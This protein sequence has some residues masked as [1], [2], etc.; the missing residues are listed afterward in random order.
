VERGI[1]TMKVLKE[2]DRKQRNRIEFNN[3]EYYSKN[4][5]QTLKPMKSK[6]QKIIL[7]KYALEE[8]ETIEEVPEYELY[9]IL[10]YSYSTLILS[11]TAF[12]GSLMFDNSTYINKNGKPSRYTKSLQKSMIEW[13]KEMKLTPTE[14]YQEK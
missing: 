8:F 14:Y 5:E 13:L 4:Y 12:T 9:Q 3:M 2:L 7:Q 11:Y 6:S 1:T 10:V